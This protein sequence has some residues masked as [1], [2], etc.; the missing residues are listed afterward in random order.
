MIV[1]I[2]AKLFGDV[3]ILG[4][5]LAQEVLSHGFG[6]HASLVLLEVPFLGGRLSFLI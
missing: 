2:V 1:L 6:R 5:D 4:L 3:L